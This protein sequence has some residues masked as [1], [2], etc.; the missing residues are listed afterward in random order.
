MRQQLAD[1]YTHI[2]NQEGDK[3]EMRAESLFKE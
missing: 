2:G 3:R 1:Q